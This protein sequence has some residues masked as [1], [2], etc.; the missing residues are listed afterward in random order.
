[1]PSALVMYWRLRFHLFMIWMRS[2]N[3]LLPCCLCSPYN[4]HTSVGTVSFEIW[5]HFLRRV[6]VLLVLCMLW[7]YSMVCSI[8]AVLSVWYLYESRWQQQECHLY[9]VVKDSSHLEC[10]WR[11][12]SRSPSCNMGMF[13]C[14]LI[15]FN[16]CTFS[17]N[18]FTSKFSMSNLSFCWMTWRIRACIGSL[19]WFLDRWTG[20]QWVWTLLFLLLLG[21]LL[22]SDFKS[23]KTFLFLN[24]L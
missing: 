6:G 8:C 16:N 23:T 18:S 22:L 3:K 7:Q 17:C 1:M 5:S 13:S 2:K 10:A 9:I 4:L 12:I 11:E 15:Q 14:L 19:K 24:Q 20:P 21:F